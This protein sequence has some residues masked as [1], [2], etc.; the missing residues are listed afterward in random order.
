MII[1]HDPVPPVDV[2]DI[3]LAW[4]LAEEEAKSSK[5]LGAV[6][7]IGGP[8]LNPFKADARAVAHRVRTLAILLD[9]AKQ[10]PE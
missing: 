1:S 10:L 4:K 5:G 3:K 9:V 8:P 6:M 2:D 7:Y